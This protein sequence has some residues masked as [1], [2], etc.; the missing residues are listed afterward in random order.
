MGLVYE[1]IKVGKLYSISIEK[2]W[3]HVVLDSNPNENMTSPIDIIEPGCVFMA[4]DIDMWEPGDHS[5]FYEDHMCIQI[6]YQE[7]IGWVILL[8][9]D[10][11]YP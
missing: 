5:H 9:E 10:I 8:P 7:K 1:D 11:E 6:L 2:G 3:N 4:L